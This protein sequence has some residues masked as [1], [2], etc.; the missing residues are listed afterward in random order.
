M[1]YGAI[2]AGLTIN[3]YVASLETA[4]VTEIDQFGWAAP[5]VRTG[6]PPPGSTYHVRIDTLGGGLYG[7]TTTQARRRFDR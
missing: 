7:F 5:P 6:N 1:E 4:W 3:D 2:G